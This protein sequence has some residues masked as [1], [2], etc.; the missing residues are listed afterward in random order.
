MAKIDLVVLRWACFKSKPRCGV[1]GIGSRDWVFGRGF[2]GK[3][4]GAVC[5]AIAHAHKSVNNVAMALNAGQVVVPTLA[6]FFL[7]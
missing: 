3:I 4:Q 2:I 7:F 5:L 1:V 6:F